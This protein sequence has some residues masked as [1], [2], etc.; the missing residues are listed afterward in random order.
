MLWTVHYFVN[1]V[2]F[3]YVPFNFISLYLFVLTFAMKLKDANYKSH[4]DTLALCDQWKTMSDLNLSHEIM[5]DFVSF[6]LFGFIIVI[7][8]RYFDFESHWNT[9]MFFDKK[10]MSDLT[11]SCQTVSISLEM[12][13]LNF[14][15]IV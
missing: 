10:I 6:S 7:K 14:I 3:A 2:R 9:L 12:Q 5:S 11:M 15:K 1:T 8:L 13:I 4:W